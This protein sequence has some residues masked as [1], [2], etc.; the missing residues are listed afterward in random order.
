MC[1]LVCIKF[2]S[3]SLQFF[4]QDNSQAFVLE[5]FNFTI[6]TVIDQLSDASGTWVWLVLLTAGAAGVAYLVRSTKGARP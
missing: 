3:Q 6:C 4:Q 5:A 2:C 1:R